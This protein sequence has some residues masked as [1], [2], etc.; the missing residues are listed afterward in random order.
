MNGAYGD[1]SM[2]IYKST[3]EKIQ[4]KIRC[5]IEDDIASIFTYRYQMKFKMN[6]KAQP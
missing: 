3:E 1:K 4:H 5:M 6:N 2:C